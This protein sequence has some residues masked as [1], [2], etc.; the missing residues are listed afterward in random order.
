MT[1]DRPIDVVVY[2]A[3]GFV[4]KLLAEYIANAAPPDA[5]IGLAGRSQSKL[6]ATRSALPAAAHDWPLVVADQ[7]DPASLVAMCEQAQVV[8]TTVGPYRRQGMKLVDACIEAGADYADLTGEVLFVHEAIGRHD[9]AAAKGVRIVHSVGFDSIP[10]DL[11][12]LLL[13][14]TA[15]AD[16]AGELEETTLVVKG[17]RG[18]VSGGT[19]GSMLGQIDDMKA[20]P[21]VK[22][23]INDPYALDPTRVAEAP[24]EREK[25]TAVCEKHKDYGLWLAPFVM[26]PYN[27]RIVRRSNGL[28]DGA[29]GKR[30]R[31]REVVSAGSSP[32]GAVVAGGMA[33]GLGGFA[34]GMSFGPTRSLLTKVLPDPGEGPSEKT[35]EKGFFKVDVYTRTSSG[36]RYVAHVSAQGDPGY[37]ATAMMMGEAALCLALDRDALPDRHGILT[38]ATAMGD[39]LVDRL[40]GAGMTLSVEKL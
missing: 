39:A 30:F 26:A 1:E 17:M 15:Q 18:G 7:N 9:D 16:G 5:R 28:L 4:G 25:D 36:A 2:G 21:E 37:K 6:E 24:G 10:S 31:Y 19:L 3:T 12:V 8:A 29:Y 23:I 22:K 13:H 32:V 40:R 38:P 27:T 20:T 11:G 34:A 35:R 14:E 33:G